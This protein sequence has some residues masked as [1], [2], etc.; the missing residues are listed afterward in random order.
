MLTNIFSLSRHKEEA[1]KG[2]MNKNTAA[3]ERKICCGRKFCSYDVIVVGAGLAGLSCAYELTSRGLKVLVLE[4]QDH[5]GGRTASFDDHGM[6]VESGLHRYIGYY[7]SLPRLL[8]KCG[9]K[10]GSILKWENT[11]EIMVKDENKKVVLGLAPLLAPVITW[12]GILGNR[13]CLSAADKLSLV[14]FFMSG[15]ISCIFSDKADNYSVAEFADRHKVSRRAKKLVVE[16]LSSGIFFLP[17]ENYSAFVFFGL[18]LPAIFKFYKMRLGAFKGGMSDVMCIPIS[19]R[20]EKQGGKI[21]TCCPVSRIIMDG[22]KAM[23]VE[24]S[25]DIE[26]M[27][28]EFFA[29]SIVLATDIT[30][31]RKILYS[32]KDKFPRSGL[33]SLETMSACTIQPSLSRP[34]FGRDV[35]VFGPGTDMVSFAEQS[36]STFKEFPGRLSVIL[37]NP[38]D[39]IEKSTDEIVKTVLDE[40]KSLSLCLEG[41]VNSVRKV[42]EK[43]KFYSLGKGQQKL[44]PLQKTAI[45]GLF[46]AGD[47]TLTSSFA[48]M[49]GAVK[50]G[51][52]AAKAVIKSFRSRSCR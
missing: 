51:R 6:T 37:G 28:D 36:H 12:K 34:A 46:L 33:F 50:S 30:S 18:F 2:F 42:Y 32:L 52:A 3:R 40:M 23:G 47:Y 41:T 35:T 26:G 9:V 1:C 13:D 25:S 5:I 4:A 7:S 17:P 24:T 16:P 15:L 48:T 39:Y 11:A 10:P 20:I 29:D 14:P 8:R 49:E 38:A 21:V 44:R 31:A 45:P 19:R 43:D 27:A 22:G